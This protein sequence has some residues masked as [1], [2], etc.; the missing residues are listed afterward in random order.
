MT[1]PSGSTTA[2]DGLAQ[3][4]SS[5]KGS[6]GRWGAGQS[7]GAVPRRVAGRW[8][9]CELPVRVDW[10]ALWALPFPTHPVLEPGKHG[11]GVRGVR[12]APTWGVK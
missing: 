9:R 11:V 7:L 1:A 12:C 2:Q 5:R 6:S 8:G 10:G 4:V 3:A